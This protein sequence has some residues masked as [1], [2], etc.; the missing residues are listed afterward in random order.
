MGAH[1]RSHGP[2]TY[3]RPSAWRPINPRGRAS[4]RSACGTTGPALEAALA[5]H[6]DARHFRSRSS[7]R[8]RGLCRGQVRRP[9]VA[10]FRRSR[11]VLR[12]RS[13][14]R[15]GRSSCRPS[16]IRRRPGPPPAD[17][18]VRKAA[19]YPHGRLW[20]A[21]PTRRARLF[22]WFLHV[23]RMPR[24]ARRLRAPACP[25]RWS[26]VDAAERRRCSPRRVAAD[27][28]LRR[29]SESG[30]SDRAVAPARRGK[31][32]NGRRSAV[33]E[34]ASLVRARAGRVGCS[35]A[36]LVAI[37]F[38]RPTSVIRWVTRHPS[39]LERGRRTRLPSARPRSALRQRS[40]RLRD[41]VPN[42]PHLPRHR[43]SSL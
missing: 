10:R 26:G 25:C 14:R 12:R 19:R 43:R 16:R 1:A 2:H 42:S 11:P 3:D 35:L 8:G 13:R 30:V 34:V 23:G 24:G 32:P 29:Y 6:C 37:R 15:P 36:S 22:A 27:R 33:R 9:A 4:R 21:I 7:A 18:S 38:G 5:A 28:L 31:R 20:R 17:F 41:R 39:N 40:R